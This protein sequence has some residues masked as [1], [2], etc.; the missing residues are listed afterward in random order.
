[1]SRV[2]YVMMNPDGREAMTKAVRE[3]IN[4]L[5]GKV[6]AEGGVSRDD[7]LDCVFVGNPIMH[8]L[9]LGIDPTELGSAPFAL[10]VSGALHFWAHEIGIDG[11]PRRAALHAALHRRPCRRRRRRR[12]AVRRPAPPGRDDAAGRCRHQCRDRARQSRPRRRRLLADRPGLRR[13]RDLRRPARRARRHR[14]RAHRSRSRSSR[15]TA[16]SASTNGRT[17]RASHDGVQRRPASPAF[18]ARRSSRW[19][20]RCIS[21]A[22]SPRTASSTARS[23]RARRASSRTAAPSPTCCDDGEPAHHRH[24][25]TTCAPSSSPRRRSMPASSC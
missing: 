18:A 22:S 21:P 25:R 17:S 11:Q 19:S 10:A 13:R 14:A 24:R 6:C 4:G 20:P 15:N 5:I 12:D 23:P 2:S 9:F 16:S 8:H 1:M 3:A 7:I